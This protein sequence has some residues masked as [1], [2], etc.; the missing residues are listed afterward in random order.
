MPRSSELPDPIRITLLSSSARR[1]EIVSHSFLD[2]AIEDS[3]GEEPRP[4]PAEAAEDYV[5]RSAVAKLGGPPRPDEEGLL[6][7][8]DTVVV[9]EGEILGKPSSKEEARSMLNRLSDAWHEV[10]TGVAVQDT[11][12]G[13]VSTGAE[14]SYVR[15]RPFDDDEVEKYVSSPEPYDKAGAYAVQDDVFRPVVMTEGCYLNIVGLPL[16]LLL[17]LMRRHDPSVELRD[18]RSI[19]YYD[20]CN[21]CKL[22]SVAEGLP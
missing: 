19:P 1:R 5:V 13:E 2:A 22:P 17:T 10:T 6:V 11:R 15:T 12:T 20:R 7:S 3:R 4:T 14:T 16:C 21:D 9:L 8:A 18:L